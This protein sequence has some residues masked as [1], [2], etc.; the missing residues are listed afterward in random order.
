MM[1]MNSGGNSSLDHLVD[2]II[3][4]RKEGGGSDGVDGGDVLISYSFLYLVSAEANGSPCTLMTFIG[5][6]FLF[7]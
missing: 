5:T 7:S 1:Y 2:D 6:Q 4:P 3:G